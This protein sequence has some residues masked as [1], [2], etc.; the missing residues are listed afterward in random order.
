MDKLKNKYILYNKTHL[1]E[2]LY[3]LFGSC[4]GNWTKTIANYKTDQRCNKNVPHHPFSVLH[5]NQLCILEQCLNEVETYC[6][7]K[8]HKHSFSLNNRQ[9]CTYKTLVNKIHQLNIF[10][11][12]TRGINF[13]AMYIKITID[14]LTPSIMPQA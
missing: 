4:I 12:V 7:S 9:L 1:Q 8:Y 14:I 11:R 13:P 10:I 5:Y 2:P 6:S 3:Y